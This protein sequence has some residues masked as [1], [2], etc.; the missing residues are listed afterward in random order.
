[1]DHEEVESRA[2]AGEAAA[3]LGTSLSDV[4]FRPGVVCEIRFL[5]G[6]DDKRESLSLSLDDPG[7]TS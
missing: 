1:M 3:F 4:R 6:I 2:R 7:M 5:R